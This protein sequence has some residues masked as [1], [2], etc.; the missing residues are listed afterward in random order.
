MG[1]ARSWDDLKS[2]MN[3]DDLTIELERVKKIIGKKGTIYSAFKIPP[4]LGV[5]LILRIRFKALWGTGTYNYNPEDNS[6][7]VLGDYDK[8]GLQ[9]RKK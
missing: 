7:I 2:K 3:S 6:I 9:Y 8:I 5:I 4:E 1:F